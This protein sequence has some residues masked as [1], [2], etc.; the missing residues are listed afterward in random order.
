[1]SDGYEYDLFLSYR[2]AGDVPMWVAN[3]FHPLL[4]KALEDLMPSTPRI[5]L[6][7]Q[8][9]IGVKW[10][11]NLAHSLRRSSHMVA[12]WSVPYFHSAWCMAEWKSMLKRERLLGMGTEDNPRGL[13]YPVVFAGSKYFPKAALDVQAQT[14]LSRWG[15]PFPAF[16]D[17]EEYI[18]FY[19]AIRQVAEALVARLNEAPPWQPNWPVVRPK[20]KPQGY[21]PPPRLVT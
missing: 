2:R 21:L 3:H 1:M 10:P 4:T 16:K 12:V 9:E 13:V 5:F 17:S 18:L 20:A 15:I 6:D 8:Q 19:K 11:N 14:D 7:K